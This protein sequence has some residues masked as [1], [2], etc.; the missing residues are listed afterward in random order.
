MPSLTVFDQLALH[1]FLADLPTDWLQRLAPLGRPVQRYTGYRFFHQ[2]GSADHFWLLTAG[3]VALDFPVPGRGDIVLE[4][5]EA[6]AVVG[7]SWLLAPHRWNLGGV[8]ADECHAVEFEA[9]R[10]RELMAED[11]ELGEEL[12]LRF[13]AVLADRLQASRVRLVELYAY[14]SSPAG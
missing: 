12:T 1:P 8:A 7:W 3:T 5:I 11:P 4:R 14:P 2:G 13:F 6:G 10:V 9:F